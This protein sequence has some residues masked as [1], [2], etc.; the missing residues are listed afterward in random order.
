MLRQLPGDTEATGL[1]KFSHQSPRYR[2]ITSRE[3]ASADH[4]RFG[5]LRPSAIHSTPTLTQLRKQRKRKSVAVV[6]IVEQRMT[7]TE[8]DSIVPSGTAENSPRF[9]PWVENARSTKPRRGE[10]TFWSWRNDWLK[11][12]RVGC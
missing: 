2:E 3:L 4:P 10:R 8:M 9:Q 1:G 5:R 12:R 11:L 7:K 6:L